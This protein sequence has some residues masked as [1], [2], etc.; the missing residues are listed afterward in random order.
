MSGRKLLRIGLL[1]D[2]VDQANRVSGWIEECGHLCDVYHTAEALQR[3]FRKT[4]FNLLIL[5]WNL[6]DSTG[7]ETLKWIRQSLLSDIPVIFV[8]IRHNEV[9]IVD[10]LEAG[11]DDYLVKPVRRQELTARVGAVLRRVQREAKVLDYGQYTF[12]TSNR[13]VTAS[14]QLVSLTEQEYDLALLFFQNRGRVIS[15]QQLL[16]SVWGNSSGASDYRTVD[17]HASRLRRKLNF[18]ASKKWKLI[19]IY[20]HG[21][22]L[23]EYDTDNQPKFKH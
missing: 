7:L 19:P 9:D 11:A 8:S 13:Q 6:P 18:N 5:D 3:A 15:R 17:I 14:S 16:A 21:Y 20:Q 12:D 10:A 4:E 22:R 2:E 23:E 1:E